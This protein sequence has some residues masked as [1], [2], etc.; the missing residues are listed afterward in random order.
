[1]R[2]AVAGV[3]RVRQACLRPSNPSSAVD[4]GVLVEDRVRGAPRAPIVLEAPG[5]HVG[6]S[7]G[8]EVLLGVELLL[9]DHG[10]VEQLD[11]R[12][13]AWWILRATDPDP[14]DAGRR[15]EVA[16]RAASPSDAR[17]VEHEAVEGLTRLH[18]GPVEVA[19]VGTTQREQERL[20]GTLIRDRRCEL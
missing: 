20:K 9:V 10:L 15:H 8:A 19:Q 3:A 17:R 1:M 13:A 14:Q 5:H 12:P 2:T 11:D 4:V 18:S 6:V 16:D 7:A